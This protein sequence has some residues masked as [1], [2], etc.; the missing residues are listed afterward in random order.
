MEN[1]KPRKIFLF[2]SLIGISSTLSLFTLGRVYERWQDSKNTLDI[3]HS[4]VLLLARPSDF[5]IAGGKWVNMGSYQSYYDPSFTG[6]I[7]YKGAGNSFLADFA[8]TDTML[9]ISHDI[10]RYVPGKK[11]KT[12]QMDVYYQ[13]AIT[14]DDLEIHWLTLEELDNKSRA[15]CTSSK[16]SSGINCYAEV[17]YGEIAST[18]SI[19]ADGMEEVEIINF[20][21]SAIQKFHD[22]LSKSSIKFGE[23]RE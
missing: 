8:T 22:R 23:E 3:N 6:M 4:L 15:F 11:P 12:T 7:P 5:E 18:F 17:S 2:L 16:V 10:R 21:T 9:G 14:T 19:W 13:G 1:S 20:L